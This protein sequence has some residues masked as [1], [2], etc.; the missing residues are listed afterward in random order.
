MPEHAKRPQNTF[1]VRFWWEWQSEGCERKVV[2]RGR[3]EHVQSGEGRTFRDLRQM[4]AF[5]EHFISPWPLRPS[6]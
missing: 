4:L 5:I 2:W 6:G 3:I 1:V